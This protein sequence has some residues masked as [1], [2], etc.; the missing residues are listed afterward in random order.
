MAFEQQKFLTLLEAERIKMKKPTDLEFGKSSLS[1]SCW[2]LMKYEEK[3]I[4]LDLLFIRALISFT[5]KATRMHHFSSFI[6]LMMRD[7]HMRLDCRMAAKFIVAETVIC[8]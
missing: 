2:V 5:T 7:Q 1:Y 4:L 8:V 6:S 3:T